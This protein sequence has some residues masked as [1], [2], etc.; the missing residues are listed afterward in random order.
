MYESDM[1]IGEL[2]SLLDASYASGGEHLLSIHTPNWRLSAR[3]LVELLQ[4]MVVLN[5]ATVNSRGEPLVG[6]V[7]GQFYRGRFHFGSSRDSLRAKHIK[8]NPNVSVAHTRGEELAVVAHGVAR[9]VEREGSDGYRKLLAEIYGQEGID[10]FWGS[11]GVVY[12][13]LEPRKMFALRPD[14]GGH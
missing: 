12:W 1:E 3:E 7:D 4:G 13:S 14:V 10:E 11:E 5:L 9:E 6:P 2:Q 8:R